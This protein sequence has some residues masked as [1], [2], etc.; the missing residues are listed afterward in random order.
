[1]EKKTIIALIFMAVLVSIPV[2]YAGIEAFPGLTSA[3]A[4]AIYGSGVS[5]VA[6]GAGVVAAGYIVYRLGTTAWKYWTANRY[7]TVTDHST[8][9]MKDFSNIWG[10]AG[11]SR[12]Q[13]DQKCKDTMNKASNMKFYQISDGRMISYDQSI[14]MMTVGETDGKTIITCTRYKLSNVNSKLAQGAWKLL[15]KY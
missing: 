14:E 12:A 3:V 5:S 9:H 10:T 4:Y 1:M 11:P 13:W 8:L 6:V 2:T 15:K 7:T